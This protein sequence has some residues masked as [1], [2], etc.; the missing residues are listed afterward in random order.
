MTEKGTLPVGI[1]AGGIVHREYELRPGTIADHI[2]AERD[3]FTEGSSI[4]NLVFIYS[5]ELV[6]LGTLPKGN[7][8]PQVLSTMHIDDYNELAAARE[9]LSQRLKSFRGAD[10]ANAGVSGGAS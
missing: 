3:G 4:A 5:R 8:T 9:R 2:E 1:E 7:I 6:R 10:K